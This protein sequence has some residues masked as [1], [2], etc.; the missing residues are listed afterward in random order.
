MTPKQAQ[1]YIYQQV[2]IM[3]EQQHPGRK[4]LQNQFCIGFLLAQL[5]H[6][7]YVD[8]ANYYRFRDRVEE[9]GYT[10]STRQKR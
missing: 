8:N 2:L 4:D 5:A 6:T 9:L 10:K 1:D 7:F 3:A